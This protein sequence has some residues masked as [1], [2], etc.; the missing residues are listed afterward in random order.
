LKGYG[1][2]A[3]LC[4]VVASL[5]L[6]T[7]VR[8]CFGTE[9]RIGVPLGRD[10][11]LAAYAAGYFVEEKTG[12][13]PDFVPAQDPLEMLKEGEIDL[14]VVPAS[15]LAKKET[16]AGKIPERPAGIVPGLGPAVFLIRADALE[17]IRFTT[18]ERSLGILP[19]FFE[20]AAYRDA[21]SSPLEPKKA[22]RKAVSD[23]L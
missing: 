8:A 16:S 7:P 10:G 22:A 13:A 19:R 5:F 23:A 3:F 12:I 4:A 1:R 11:A 6:A 2:I 17:D 20:G 15:A 14:A 9:L 21:Q 18:L